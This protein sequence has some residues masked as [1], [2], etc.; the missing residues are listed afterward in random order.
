MDREADKKPKS[1]AD[2]LVNIPNV[3]K[4]SFVMPRQGD[5]P[6]ETVPVTEPVPVPKANIVP[7]PPRPDPKKILRTYESDVADAME[8]KKTSVLTMAMAEQQRSVGND[9][10]SNKKEASDVGPNLFKVLI[11]VLLIFG[12]IGGGYYLYMKSPLAPLP[13]APAGTVIIPGVVL[14]NTQKIIPIDNL[15][16]SGL[17][18][19]INNEKNTSSKVGDLHEVILSFVDRDGVQKRV[20][21]Q[22]FINA[23]GF[24]VPDILER[25]TGVKF[26]LAYVKTLDMNGQAVSSP[27]LIFTNTFFQNAFAG[28]LRWEGDLAN[29]FDRVFTI[30]RADEF[31]D[32]DIPI[33]ISGVISSTTASSTPSDTSTST[34]S[35][36][37]T[38][39]VVARPP[40]AF[41]GLVGAWSDRTLK[42]KDIRVY[43]DDANRDILMYSFVD[44]DTVVITTN[45]EAMVDIIGR[46]EKQTFVR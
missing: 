29:Q 24:T 4:G 44:K 19:A 14:P 33:D 40:T 41:F 12:G 45:E 42:N 1:L 15:D 34:G 21:G 26:M 43:T 9:S 8:R 20:T 6:I 36:T 31:K 7:E 16:Q 28:M 27:V 18:R 11:G 17:I 10:I 5:N 30:R 35:T 37:P 32:S 23:I 46:I 13:P 2:T 3:T 38:E 25:S 39:K 22:Q